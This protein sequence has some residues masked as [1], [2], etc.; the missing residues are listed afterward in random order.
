MLVVNDNENNRH[1]VSAILLLKNICIPEAA[2]CL[3]VL[4][5]IAKDNVY[6]AIIIDCHMPYM[7][8][9]EITKKIRQSLLVPEKEQSLFCL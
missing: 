2:N 6:D 3:E 8:G 7:D 5:K 4:Q 1:I 9:L